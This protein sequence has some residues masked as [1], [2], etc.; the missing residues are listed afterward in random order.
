M[1]IIYEHVDEFKAREGS[2]TIDLVKYF[3]EG[4]VLC[5]YLIQITYWGRCSGHFNCKWQKLYV[6]CTILTTEFRIRSPT[7]TNFRT[8]APRSVAE[9]PLCLYLSRSQWPRVLIDDEPRAACTVHAENI[10]PWAR[11]K[12][13]LLL[14][15]GTVSELST[16]PEPDVSASIAVCF[17][18]NQ[19]NLQSTDYSQH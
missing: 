1:E 19:L 12:R 8:E 7:F 18:P 17:K 6:G 2:E 10:D 14:S 11:P 16:C 15:R 3:K 5:S 13:V 4:P 9:S